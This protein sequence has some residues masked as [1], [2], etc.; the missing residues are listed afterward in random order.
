M[1]F[2]AEAVR[3]TLRNIDDTD[4]V[5]DNKKAKDKAKERKDK[6]AKDKAK[7]RKKE[8]DKGKRSY[9]ND[10]VEQT[11]NKLD[12]LAS[13][14][15]EEHDK[16]RVARNKRKEDNK[17]DNKDKKEDKNKKKSKGMSNADK[18][19]E[20]K[21]KDEKKQ[22]EV[23][24]KKISG[25]EKDI[26]E[27]EKTIDGLEDKK[28]DA[29]SDDK[30]SYKGHVINHESVKVDH[31]TKEIKDQKKILSTK[32]E[33]LL[34]LSDETREDKRDKY[35][36]LTDT[37][38]TLEK[39]QRVLRD[40]LERVKNSIKTLRSEEL[41]GKNALKD[42]KPTYEDHLTKKRDAET[43]KDSAAVDK[44]SK[45]LFII[46]SDEM[47]V[48]LT[49]EKDVRK[50]LDDVRKKMNDNVK[51]RE[52]AAKEAGIKFS[53][54]EEQSDKKIDQM[55]KDDVSPKENYRTLTETAAKIKDRKE[56]LDVMGKKDM[57]MR[58]P[59]IEED[60]DYVNETSSK[61]VKKKYD[62]KKKKDSSSS[63]P[64]KKKDNK[65]SEDKTVRRGRLMSNSDE[66]KA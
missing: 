24:N 2:Q 52:K 36:A 7:D 57:S 15:K 18:R 41:K 43:H 21:H 53:S 48:L 65:V 34:K 55:I 50:D 38:N 20:K 27:I 61:P 8:D 5:A 44:H 46:G 40:K 14:N 39:T 31:L 12:T 63:K 25:L 6:K 19:D 1:A 17:E 16:A 9:R 22:E 37:A 59:T 45:A 47:K 51:D 58:R 42:D 35:Y 49:T 60:V 30:K 29:I 32:E 13:V 3:S 66:D 11:E 4:T 56:D 26:K 54:R 28:S 64:M 10:G 33:S 62:N 23:R